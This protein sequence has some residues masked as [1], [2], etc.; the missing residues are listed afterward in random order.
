MLEI[1]KEEIINI[2]KLNQVVKDEDVKIKGIFTE[3]NINRISQS[4]FGDNLP[5]IPKNIKSV[6]K[7]ML[8]SKKENG[9]NFVEHEKIRIYELKEVC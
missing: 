9:I 1:Q 3:T 7:K 6:A 8:Q 2:I 5:K 4:C